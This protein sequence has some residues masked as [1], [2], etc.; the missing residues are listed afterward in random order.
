MPYMASATSAKSVTEKQECQTIRKS[1]RDV[2]KVKLRLCGVT[3]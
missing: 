1:A 2:H 3:H